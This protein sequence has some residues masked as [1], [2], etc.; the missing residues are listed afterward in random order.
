MQPILSDSNSLF[1]VSH[2]GN[3][4]FPFGKHTAPGAE[5][6]VFGLKNIEGGQT[7]F[8]Y[9]RESLENNKSMKVYGAHKVIQRKA[10]TAM[11]RLR[12]SRAHWFSGF[13]HESL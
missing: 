1:Y 12:L 8:L 3:V 2:E 13:L 10:G 9:H 5:T 7:F 4:R 6:Y 11:Y